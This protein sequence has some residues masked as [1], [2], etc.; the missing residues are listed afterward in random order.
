MC[1][2]SII[3][4]FLHDRLQ[5]ED[6]LASVLQNRPG[7]SEVLVVHRGPYDDPYQLDG[8]VQFVEVPVDAQLIEAV[9]AGLSA[10][11]GKIVHLLSSGVL[12]LEGWTEP[13]LECFDD[14]LVGA[15]S[16]V[17]LQED[18]QS[19]VLSAGVRYT[20]GGRRLLNGLGKNVKRGRRIFRRRT[21]GPSL[22]AGFYRR[23]V[24]E[25]LGGFCTTVGPQFSDVDLGLCLKALDYH[26]AVE[27]ESVVVGDA[28]DIATIDCFRSG[29]CAER[30]FWRQAGTNG[31]L[32]SLFFHPFVVVG[33]VLVGWRRLGTYAS[34]LGRAVGMIQALFGR[35][36]DRARI[37]EAVEFLEG[38]RWSVPIREDWNGDPANQEEPRRR[39]A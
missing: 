18:D 37:E 16:P 9:N 13:A 39:A 23:S 33:S 35:K 26:S 31:W 29:R 8:E 10:A 17:V 21:A 36:R 12:A 24:I 11:V 20:F 3:V 30:V 25:A 27:P 14:P 2:L 6:T 7:D 1:R 34:L 4:P 32:S 22:A 5:F 19:T 38:D 15:V 28:A